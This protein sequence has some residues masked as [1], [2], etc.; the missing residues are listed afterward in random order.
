MPVCSAEERLAV[1][2][3][4][5]AELNARARVGAHEVLQPKAPGEERIVPKVLAIEGQEIKGE[6]DQVL[7][8]IADRG[9]QGVEAGYAGFVLD[10]HLAV[11]HGRSTAQGAA[12]STTGP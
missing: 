1:A 4:I 3:V 11:K 5:R 10:A 7:R 8:P 9:A 2:L 6:E 12:A